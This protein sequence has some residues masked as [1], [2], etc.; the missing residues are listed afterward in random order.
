MKKYA[1]LTIAAAVALGVV[2]YLVYSEDDKDE[3]VIYVVRNVGGRKG[4]QQH[5]DAW[6]AAFER[7]N[8]GW[9]MKLINVGNVQGTDFYMSRIASDDLPEVVQ[10]WTLTKFFADNGHLV[11]LPD[12]YYSK[13]GLPL[14]DPY[15]SKRYATMGS[16]Q[17]LGIA[18]NMKMWREI[19]V[20][21]PPPT[22]D[23]FVAALRKLKAKGH[24]DEEDK[25]VKAMT[26]GARE[27][28]GAVPLQY[29]LFANL[30]AYR[31]EKADIG[32][33]SWT[34]RKDA[35]KVSF[36]K[37]PIA[38]KV[39]QNLIDLLGEF[40]DEGAADAGYKEDKG[41]F[42]AGRSATWL[43]GCWIGGDLEPGEVDL[44][45]EYWPIPSMVGRKPIFLTGSYMQTGWAVTVKATGA[46]RDKAFAVLDALNDPKVYQTW[47]NAES[48]IP[49]ATKVRGVTGPKSDFPAAKRFYA[50]MIANHQKYGHSR[51]AN[52]AMDDTVP[53]GIEADF[54]KIMQSIL[55][56]EKDVQKLLGRLDKAWEIGRKSEK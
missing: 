43:M 17:L 34:R 18:V 30:Y 9:K 25:R 22:W 49:T 23:E 5:F 21:E 47:L 52:I 13:F 36:A 19:G 37:D 44:E 38:R 20:T 8:P 10:T 11:P 28:S 26:Y 4:F 56:G 3:N 54:L 1:L 33:E 53:V 55:E 42:Y 50:S 29:G 6:K 46:K 39:M 15:K 51:G 35:G 41:E 24:S 31:G 32:A 40:A 2:I 12:T 16:T 45:I 48:M 14:P 27:W 7:D